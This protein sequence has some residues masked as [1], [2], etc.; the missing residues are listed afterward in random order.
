[1]P[2]SAI[3]TIFLVTLFAWVSYEYHYKGSFSF[4]TKKFD[5]SYTLTDFYFDKGGVAAINVTPV[6][7]NKVKYSLLL[8]K[9]EPG[10]YDEQ[11]HFPD[12]DLQV[13]VLDESSETHHGSLVITKRHNY[14]LY[15]YLYEGGDSGFSIEITFLNPG[16]EHLSLNAVPNKYTHIVITI[17]WL[18]LSVLGTVNWFMYFYFIIVDLFFFH[19]PFIY[20]FICLFIKQQVF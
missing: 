12:C 2:S 4:D 10:D 13:D 15:L 18:I 6:P 7:K 16:N 19:F 1:M 20:S 8:C 17:V 5:S 14:F 3:Q 11:Y 9:D